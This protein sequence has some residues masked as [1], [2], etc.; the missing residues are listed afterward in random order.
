[1]A[2]NW[3]S[4]RLAHETI[5]KNEAFYCDECFDLGENFTCEHARE[6]KQE[7][8]A[9]L[10]RA[11]RRARRD[12]NTSRAKEFHGLVRNLLGCSER[13]RCGSLECPE[14]AR[15]IQCAKSLAHQEFC[16]VLERKHPDHQ[17]AFATIIPARFSLCPSSLATLDPTFAN[18]WFKDQLRGLE[19]K[20]PVVGSLDISWEQ[21]HYQVHWHVAMMTTSR[22]LLQEQLSNAFSKDEISKPA[23]AKLAY[24]DGFIRYSHKIIELPDLLRRARKTIPE[25]CLALNKIEPL[26]PLILMNTR[27]STFDGQLIFRSIEE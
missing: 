26:A 24:S 7:L 12:K 2:R 1:M 23:I 10:Q 19:T 20:E 15:A 16:R 14:C 5:R 3:K 22:D 11:E 25:L 21:T 13:S 18:R 8:I 27:L 17:L 4:H 9:I 6:R